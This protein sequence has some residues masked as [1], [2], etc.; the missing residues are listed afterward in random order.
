ME[1]GSIG[2][3]DSQATHILAAGTTPFC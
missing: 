1:H 2:H 3:A